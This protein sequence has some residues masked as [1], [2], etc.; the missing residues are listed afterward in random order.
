MNQDE[1]SAQ[2]RLWWMITGHW[3]SQSISVVARLGIADL[4]ADGPKTSD[5][6]ARATDVNPDRLYRVL[7]FVAGME[8]FTQA[9]DRRFGLT[10][11]SECLRSNLKSSARYH[12]VMFGGEPYQAWGN[13]SYTVRTG[14]AAFDH[15]FGVPYFDYL[16]N[17]PETATW[18]NNAM[19]AGRWR[20]ADIATAYDFTEVKQVVDVGGGH[21]ALLG[22]IL[23][24]HSHVHGVVFDLPQVVAGAGPH[25][26]GLGLAGRFEAVG[27]SFFE[28]APSGGDV[29]ILSQI[30][31]DWD[32]EPS[33]KILRT[34]RAAMSQRAR[35]LIVDR[36]VLD[37]DQRSEAKALDLH[38]MVLLGGRER[39]ER[40]WS[41][42][43]ADAGFTLQ[44][45]IPLPTGTPIIEA[46][47][48]PTG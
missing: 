11:L 8:V 30:L 5:E 43:L 25:L 47:P 10:P 35:L 40:E 27:G 7:R 41:S 45:I 13:L 22:Y 20:A 1:L 36:V 33:L 48:R 38:M 46:R 12:A 28:T 32:D 14:E 21:G 17:H 31:H 3:L 37:D 9:H 24:A 18:F 4:L 39:T 16:G 34:C 2:Q 19:T 42:L 23:A 6:L 29:Y 15:T 44:R 26:D